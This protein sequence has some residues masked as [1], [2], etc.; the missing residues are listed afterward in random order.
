MVEAGTGT[1]LVSSPT[2]SLAGIF[3]ERDY[4]SKLAHG[5]Y[6][7]QDICVGQVMGT[8]AAVATLDAPLYSVLRSMLTE[9]RRHTPVLTPASASVHA[10]EAAA[11]FAIEEVGSVISLRDVVGALST[12]VTDAQRARGLSDDQM[13]KGQPQGDGEAA[14]VLSWNSRVDDMLAA[15]KTSGRRILLNSQLEDN[16]TVADAADVM[17]EAG[18]SAILVVDAD[19]CVAGIFTSRDLLSR[20]VVLGT[21]VNAATARVR[22]FMTRDP[23]TISTD[24]SLL[25]GAIMMARMGFR[26]LPVVSDTGAL[27]GILSMA[28]LARAFLP[29]SLAPPPPLAADAATAAA[30]AVA[31]GQVVRH[32]IR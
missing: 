31:E 4:V 3:S 16:L 28:D 1:L 19:G 11:P 29:P 17:A 21:G 18:N 12:A 22:D 15:M 5:S 14:H 32:I 13:K 23:V 30:E 9:G 8:A 24:R 27:I 7:P 6:P 25:R 20:V 2:G 10:G 26:H